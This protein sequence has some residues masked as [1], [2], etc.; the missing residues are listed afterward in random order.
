MRI[1]AREI[2]HEHLKLLNDLCAEYRLVLL[3]ATGVDPE[4]PKASRN[5]MTAFV[6]RVPS[7]RVAVDV[8]AHRFRNAAKEWDLNT[9]HDI[10]A[11]SLAVPYCHVVV[12]DREIADLLGRSKAGPRNGTHVLRGLRGL[13]DLLADLART[14]AGSPRRVSDEDWVRK[15]EEFCMTMEDLQRHGTAPAGS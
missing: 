15:G 5:R 8:K 2:I 7:V 9:V 3:Q 4:R 11:V 1:Q 12:P 13:P 10:D 6:D 14:A